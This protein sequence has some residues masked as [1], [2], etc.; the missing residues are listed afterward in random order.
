MLVGCNEYTARFQHSC[1]LCDYPI[2]PGD[3]YLRKTHLHTNKK[4]RC[5]LVWREHINPPCPHDPR[6]YFEDT[7]T[8][9][10]AEQLPLD[11]KMAA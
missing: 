6:D 4:Y 5:V 7:D 3:Q 10:D 2:L 8:S 1:D 9:V 11:F